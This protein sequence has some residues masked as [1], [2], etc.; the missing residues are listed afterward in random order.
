MLNR[1][2]I[3]L[4]LF[5]LAACNPAPPQDEPDAYEEVTGDTLAPLPPT[6]QEEEMFSGSWIARNPDTSEI[7]VRWEVRVEDQRWKGQY[8]LTEHFCQTRDGTRTSAC[9]FAGQSG[10]WEQILAGGGVLN[11]SATDPYQT[12]AYFTLQMLAP[13]G[14]AVSTVA[15]SADLGFVQLNTDIERD[16]D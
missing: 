15:F 5:S 12:D 16:D 1:Y 9:P 4:G 3:L 8:A 13:D 10:S 14:A 7:M 6:A 2:I 11:A